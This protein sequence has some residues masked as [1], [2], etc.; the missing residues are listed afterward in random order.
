M[1]EST[2]KEYSFTEHQEVYELLEKLFSQYGVSYYL[3]G[4]NARDVQ[5]YKQGIKPMRMTGDIDFAVM[6]P[7]IDTYEELFEELCNLGFRKIKSLP[8][9]LI[10]EKTDTA[11][12]ILPYGQI[13]QEYTIKFTDRNLELSVLGFKE[14]GEFI[15][16][17]SIEEQ[18]LTL[19]VTPIEGIFILKLISWS[20][21]PNDREKDLEDLS[22]LLKHAWDLYEVEA[23]QDHLDLFEEEDF[24]MTRAAA[25]II[26]RKM[27]PIIEN[28]EY[29]YKKIVEII[30]AGVKEKETAE[31]LEIK[32]TQELNN[33]IEETQQILAQV[34]KGLSGR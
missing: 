18:G 24:D 11:L 33:S 25:K 3:I 9:R 13:E 8:Y 31:M 6:V 16:N 29:L 34:L 19:P 17:V 12:D 21:K 23:Y 30:E 28:N 15:E 5:L 7:D 22:F 27:K 20:E 1:S 10:F 4:A 26:G 32:I 2:F 14:V